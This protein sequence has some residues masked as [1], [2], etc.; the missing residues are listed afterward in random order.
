MFLNSILL[1]NVAVNKIKGCVYY[2]Q[3]KSLHVRM[4]MAA[5]YT[6]LV[7]LPSP[8]ACFTVAASAAVFCTQ[9]HVIL[10]KCGEI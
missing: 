10:L 4:C 9:P 8:A 3:S 2:L 7:N 6:P 1:E 5:K